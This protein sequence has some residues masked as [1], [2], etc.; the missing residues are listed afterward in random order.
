MHDV[1][2][3]QQ[4]QG[5]RDKRLV[6]KTFVPLFDQVAVRVHHVSETQGGVILPDG[7]PDPDQT[8]IC[9]V[10]ACGPDC[11]HIKE[12]MTLVVPAATQG[13]RMVHGGSGPVIIF[14]EDMLL[15]GIELPADEVER[16]REAANANKRDR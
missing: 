6:Y 14:K 3:R 11:K 12:G 13:T 4:A 16:N 10:I 5:P 7:V 15:C 2:S 1:F 9:T 8:P